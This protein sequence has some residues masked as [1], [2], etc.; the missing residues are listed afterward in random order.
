[1]Q[2][3][4]IIREPTSTP[5]EQMNDQ[6]FD[7]VTLAFQP[8]KC[9]GLHIKNVQFS[10]SG[11]YEC[12]VKSIYDTKMTTNATIAF[13]VKGKPWLARPMNTASAAPPLPS[14]QQPA[15]VVEG[16][17]VHLSAFN[18]DKQRQNPGVDQQQQQQ[19]QKSEDTLM[20]TTMTAT[21]AS[22]AATNSSGAR[23]YRT[24]GWM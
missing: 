14:A 11:K 18:D 16:I 13:V 20:L 22:V 6:S 24:C 5:Y 23:E 7:Q 8:V 15:L 1:M 3:G 19:Q 4:T 12:Q 9:W 17:K 21:I 10:D 2:N